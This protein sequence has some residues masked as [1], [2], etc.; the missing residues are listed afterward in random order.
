MEG[1]PR[2]EET[3]A[4]DRYLDLA[5]KGTPFHLLCTGP[6]TNLAVALSL[7]N[8]KQLLSFWENCQRA[9]F[10]GGNFLSPGNITRSAEF[11]FHADPVAAQ[12]VLTFYREEKQRG[13]HIP[14]LEFIPLDITEKV[15]IDV[16]GNDAAA[17]KLTGG[18][19]LL[20]YALKEYGTFHA[21]AA[22]RPEN[23]DQFQGEKHAAAQILGGGGVKQ[24]KRFCHLHDPVAAWVIAAEPKDLQWEK[25]A[26][27]RID[28]GMGDSRGRVIDCVPKS[29]LPFPQAGLGTLVHWLKGNEFNR[30]LIV[31]GL[32]PELKKL[33]GFKTP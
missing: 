9:V 29:E 13:G 18:G 32:V 10:M 22:S 12:M 27:I 33:I 30:G 17:E 25:K 28:T 4:S 5:N 31:A 6:L 20:R 24:L 21:L 14:A 7:M 15:G 2:V 3:S 19:N 1:M 16:D 23:V 8:R 26:E 11:N